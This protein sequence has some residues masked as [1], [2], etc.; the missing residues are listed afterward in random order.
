MYSLLLII[1]YFAFISLGLGDSLLPSAWPVMHGQFSTPITYA[2]IVSMTISAG[3]ITSALLS[4]RLTKKFSVRLVVVF[5]VCLSLIALFGFSF[6]GSLFTLWIWALPYG[7]GAG[8]LDATVNNYVAV[9]YK[10][11]HMNWLHSFWGVGAM[12]G[13]YIMGFLLTRGFHWS[14]GY[15][16]VVVIQLVLLV[17]LICSM[18]MW[19]RPAKEEEK[20]A[21]IKPFSEIISI[22]G[23]KFV[24]LALFAYCAIEATT[25]LWASSFLVTYRNI[26]P[27]IAAGLA[28]LFFMGITGGRFLSGFVS[29]KFG[30]KN[31][32]KAGIC[33]ILAGIVAVWLPLEI[34]M[35]SFVGL[36]TI[37]V[38]CAP[39]FPAIIHSTPE[40]F[41]SEN[42]Q[43]L[44]GMQMASA[45][46]GS[47]LMPPLFGF[48]SSFF[49]MNMFPVYLM[50]FA[51][52]L[53]C[54]ITALNKSIRSSRTS[55]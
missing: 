10:S 33:L 23:V 45:Y 13:P 19:K 29:G 18:A 30:N 41:G 27:E 39:I 6:A 49:G 8:A 12:V 20:T 7:L 1:I 52:L 11:K 2:G 36:I 28:S 35:I 34:N 37:G 26:S 46:T 31:M 17:V 38:G 44:V 3:T 48:I 9:H 5:S 24:L 32:I 15:R 43:A 21:V 42:S 50:F 53:I 25:A 54:M 14:A 16:T 47:A 22:R 4:D 55:Q 51:V 40:S